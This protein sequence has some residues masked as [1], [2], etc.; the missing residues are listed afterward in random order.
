[1][2]HFCTETDGD[3]SSDREVERLRQREKGPEFVKKIDSVVIEGE[4]CGLSRVGEGV[5]CG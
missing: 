5:Q 4:Q 1:M 3:R 2:L